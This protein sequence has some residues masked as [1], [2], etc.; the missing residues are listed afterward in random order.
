MAF[1]LPKLVEEGEIP[2]SSEWNKM[3]ECLRA[4]FPLSSDDIEASMADGGTMHKLRRPRNTVDML[5]PFKIIGH[6]A[7]IWTVAYG[8]VQNIVPTL[9]GDALDNGNP[10]QGSGQGDIYLKVTVQD[11]EG[12][13]DPRVTGAVVNVGSCPDNDPSD[14]TEAYILLGEFR[15]VNG[16]PVAN[17]AVIHSLQYW[18]MRAYQY[19]NI[20][21]YHLFGAV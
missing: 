14:G 17:Q 12:P 11:G 19:E 10:P 21:Y 8:T 6:P 3:V 9:N 4:L 2:S 13:D 18:R 1:E 20:Q 16:M 5:H 7:G 15:M